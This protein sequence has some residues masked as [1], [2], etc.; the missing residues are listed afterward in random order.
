[1]AVKEV[2]HKRDIDVMALR[3]DN[4]IKFYH[5]Y[6]NVLVMEYAGGP[7]LAQ[8]MDTVGNMREGVAIRISRGLTYLRSLSIVHKNIRPDNIL[9]TSKLDVKIAG[10]GSDDRDCDVEWLA[11]ELRED[12]NRYSYQSDIYNLGVLMEKMGEGSPKYLEWMGLCQSKEPNDR[13]LDCLLIQPPPEPLEVKDCEMS[14]EGLDM[15]E[16]HAL[17]GNSDIGNYL[18]RMYKEG[19]KVPIDKAKAL[20]WSELAAKDHA[21]A[22]NTM[23]L[24]Y[25]DTDPIAAEKWFLK[26]VENGYHQA[27]SNL[28][29]LMSSQNRHGK[30]KEWYR[31]ALASN[32]AHAQYSLGEMYFRGTFVRQ[33]DFQALELFHKAAVQGH[34]DAQYSVGYMHQYERGTKRDDRAAEE[35]YMKAMKQGHIAAER[36]LAMMRNEKVLQQ[37]AQDTLA[38]S[39]D[40]VQN[41]DTANVGDVLKNLNLNS[42]NPHEFFYHAM[43]ER[44]KVSF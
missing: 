2:V 12:P 21:G 9:L 22:Q 6:D 34:A 5:Q 3:N 44:N 15:L 11:P 14:E 33:N 32:D 41:L 36:S 26:A 7:T 29:R 4:I 39:M 20:H 28:G 8:V 30:A 35:W 27:R 25:F 31:Q 37:W 18:G 42:R 13:P 1:M 10:F 38:V 43:E 19:F 16:S 23:G 17:Q 40:V 24:H